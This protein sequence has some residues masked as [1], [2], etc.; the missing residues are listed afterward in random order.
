MGDL[1]SRAGKPDKAIAGFLSHHGRSQ[2]GRQIG[3]QAAVGKA[4]YLTSLALH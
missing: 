3:T 2:Q 4:E 1:S